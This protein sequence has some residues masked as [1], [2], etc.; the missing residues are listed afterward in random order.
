MLHSRLH[1]PRYLFPHQRKPPKQS[2]VA[3]LSLYF[4]QALKG[5]IQ[6]CCINF[7]ALLVLAQVRKGNLATKHLFHFLRLSLPQL[8]RA[9]LDSF[10]SSLD[11][12]VTR[13][14][15]AT[16]CLQVLVELC[17]AK[18][19]GVKVLIE[20]MDSK[21]IGNGSLLPPHLNLQ[22]L[23]REQQLLNH[24]C[25]FVS[26]VVVGIFNPPPDAGVVAVVIVDLEVES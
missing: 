23:Q 15:G 9:V 22:Q 17:W 10:A 13:P 3:S 25:G 2:L 18:L 21:P 26:E 7:H 5:G 1:E 24:A 16:D 4:N 12:A 6:R 8:L 19:V 20:E 11:L 14:E